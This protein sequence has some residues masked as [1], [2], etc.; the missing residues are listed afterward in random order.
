MF[1]SLF[2]SSADPFE[3]LRLLYPT[4]GV[5][6]TTPKKAE[7]I[8]IRSQSFSLISDHQNHAKKFS[9]LYYESK[10]VPMTYN[11]DR[12]S[13]RELFLFKRTPSFVLDHVLEINIYH[14]ERHFICEKST[15]QIMS[16]MKTLSRSTQLR[17]DIC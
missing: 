7:K 6:Y 15:I 14:Y 8:Y 2:T 4:H 11:P 3:I 10:K 9:D 5:T 13:Q 1:V 17:T 16:Q 12:A